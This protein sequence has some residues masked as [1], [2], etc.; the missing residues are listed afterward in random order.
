MQNNTGLTPV[1]VV[2][3]QSIR[4]LVDLFEGVQSESSVE[5]ENMQAV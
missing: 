4:M 2:Y 1:Y 5:V 3:G